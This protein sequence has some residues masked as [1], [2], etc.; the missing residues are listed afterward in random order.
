MRAGTDDPILKYVCRNLWCRCP[1]AQPLEKCPRCGLAANF[2]LISRLRKA[3]II[4]GLLLTLGGGVMWCL[5]FAILENNEWTIPKR[6]PFWAFLL[7][8]ALGGL[9]IAGGVSLAVF[10]REWFMRMILKCFGWREASQG[11]KSG[12]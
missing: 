6:T 12:Y 11:Q 3:H 8:L 5:G 1:A 4:C 2:L 7:I 9:P 10:G